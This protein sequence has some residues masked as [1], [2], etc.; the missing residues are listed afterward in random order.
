[1]DTKEYHNAYALRVSS[2]HKLATPSL[3]HMV[4]A[5]LGSAHL[6]LLSTPAVSQTCCLSHF[7]HWWS[8]SQSW[9]WRRAQLCCQRCQ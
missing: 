6:S 9:A 7:L 5:S 3:Y 4:F 8:S 1:M 2:P